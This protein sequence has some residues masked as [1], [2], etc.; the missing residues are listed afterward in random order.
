MPLS[1]PAGACTVYGE[2]LSPADMLRFEQDVLDAAVQT[3][4]E[5]GGVQ[6]LAQAM[7]MKASTLQHKLNPL[8]DTHHLRLVEGARMVH[9][10]R[11]PYVLQAIGAPVNYVPTRTRP[12]CAEGDPLE[13][14]YALQQSYADLIAAAVDALRKGSATTPN[15]YRRVEFAANEAM[16]AINSLVS[17]AAVR[18]PERKVV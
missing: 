5:F 3:A 6:E 17:A 2:K 16:A 7:G 4:R 9:V 15:Q 10:T 12:D 8:N 13:A 11:L 14:F 1:V 18:V